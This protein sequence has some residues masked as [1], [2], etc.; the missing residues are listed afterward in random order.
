MEINLNESIDFDKASLKTKKGK[1]EL[2]VKY[3][4]YEFGP[5]ITVETD[6]IIKIKTEKEHSW[7]ILVKKNLLEKD[8]VREETEEN[9]VEK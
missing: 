3:N 7:Q 2:K 8:Q 4:K 5:E 9:N 1:I 6:T